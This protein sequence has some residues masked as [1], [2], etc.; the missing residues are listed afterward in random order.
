MAGPRLFYSIERR[1]HRDG[2]AI[3]DVD[4]ELLGDEPRRAAEG[5]DWVW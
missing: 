1:A 4:G 2:Y 5:P 3:R